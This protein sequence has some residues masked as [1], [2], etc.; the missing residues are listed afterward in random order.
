[1]PW[2]IERW[3]LTYHGCVISHV[4]SWAHCSWRGLMYG[5]RDANSVVSHETGATAGSVPQIF[6][7]GVFFDAAPEGWLAEG[8]AVTRAHLERLE[9]QNGVRVGPGDAVLVRTGHT[10]ARTESVGGFAINGTPACHWDVAEWLAE[11][12]VAIFGSDTSNDVAPP[13]VPAFSSPVH[14]LALVGMGMPLLD[15]LDLEALAET[16]RRKRRSTFALAIC[17][18]RLDGATGS[19]VNAMALF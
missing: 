14:V 3:E 17:P 15:N 4:D 1:M 16:I 5:G 18:L 12:R 10:K 2:S 11:R 7:R 13:P 19:P 8:Q 6:T 9:T